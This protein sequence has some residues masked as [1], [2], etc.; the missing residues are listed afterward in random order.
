MR[1]SVAALGA[2]LLAGLALGCA[3]QES[4]KQTA[5]QSAT[6][7]AV[8]EGEGLD[9]PEATEPASE[10]AIA[11]VG[12]AEWFKYPDGLQIQVTKLKRFTVSDDDVGEAKPGDS[13][14]LVTITIKNG[15]PR[16]V[17]IDGTSVHVSHGPNGDESESVYSGHG[18]GSGFTGSIPPNRSRTATYGFVVPKAHLNQVAIEVDPGFLDY[19]SAHFEGA[20]K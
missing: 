2:L 5:D 15:S 11:K 16:T 6:P 14:V 3:A 19:E 12:S 9:T 1:K 4:T 13:A 10:P 7:P 17:D 18:I 8:V 20:A